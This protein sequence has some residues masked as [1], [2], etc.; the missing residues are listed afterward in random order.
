MSDICT[1]EH[2]N[3]VADKLG[4]DAETVSTFI[5]AEVDYALRALVQD[6]AKYMRHSRRLRLR[7]T[8]VD[9]ALILQ[10][11]NSLHGYGNSDPVEFLVAQDKHDTTQKLFFVK[12]KEID[13]GQIAN[14]VEKLPPVP[15][16]P[17]HS[18]HWLAIDGVQPSIVENPL[19][20]VEGK[21]KKRTDLLHYSEQDSLKRRKTLG[22]GDDS[23]QVVKRK[24]AKHMLSSELQLYYKKLISAVE[25]GAVNKSAAENVFASLSVD[26][27]LQQ[28]LPYLTKY[29]S[30]QV[31]EN[32]TNLPFLFSTMRLSKC[33]IVNPNLKTEL[34]LHQLM[35]PILTCL[36]SK[37]LCL[38]GFEDHW[39]LRNLAATLIKK[40]CDQY[41][42]TYADL[43]P[44]ITKTLFDALKEKKKPM[45]T[46]Y[47]T[48]VGLTALG[49]LT[50]Q[51]YLLPSMIRL[52]NRF[53]KASRSKIDEKRLEAQYCLGALLQAFGIYFTRT[54]M[55]SIEDNEVLMQKVHK[56]LGETIIPWC[57]TKYVV[58]VFI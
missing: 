48:I 16:Q 55:Q 21:K 8:D 7:T 10:G 17:T 52:L 58:E 1:S 9:N 46:Q 13:L 33:L 18:I 6:A 32:L 24:I 39:S 28:L 4:V 47:G 38:K 29:V 34:Y 31:T 40:V 20:S 53:K 42:E 3:V 26:P 35:P 51:T 5:C 41:A 27:G 56:A 50:I 57:P 15:V 2:V 44:R 37:R 45:T 14:G 25:E 49:P 12:E 54:S 43:Q 30:E 36:V 22:L 23:N 11:Q 19:V